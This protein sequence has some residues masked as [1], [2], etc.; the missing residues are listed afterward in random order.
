M[1]AGGYGYRPRQPAVMGTEG[2]GCVVAAGAG[3]KHLKEGDRALF[4]PPAWAE[5]IKTDAPLMESTLGRIPPSLSSLARRLRSR[6]SRQ[7]G[8]P[9]PCCAYSWLCR[10]WRLE[11]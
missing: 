5:R 4:L 1:I 3:V 6:V 11:R 8:S 10:S 2:A 7:I 9:F